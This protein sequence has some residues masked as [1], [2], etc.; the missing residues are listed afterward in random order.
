MYWTTY[1]SVGL[2]SKDLQRNRGMSHKDPF[3]PKLLVSVLKLSL[4]DY[5]KTLSL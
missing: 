3:E 1:F 2:Q 4:S 5:K